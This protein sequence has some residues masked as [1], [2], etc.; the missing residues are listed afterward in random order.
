MTRIHFLYQID[1]SLVLRQ[2]PLRVGDHLRVRRRPIVRW[3]A[4]LLGRLVPG[5]GG[6]RVAQ[7]LSWDLER[8]GLGATGLGAHGAGQVAVVEEPLVQT[9]QA[10][11]ARGRSEGT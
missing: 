3:R 2:R 8:P 5:P 11:L 4:I 7:L 10:D 9:H 1:R 6:W